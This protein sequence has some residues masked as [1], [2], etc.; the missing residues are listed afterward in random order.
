MTLINPQS[1]V[2][3]TPP[4]GQPQVLA[5]RSDHVRTQ[6]NQAVRSKPKVDR[7]TRQAPEQQREAHQ[8]DFLV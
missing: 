5:P 7:L 4:L 6:L 1:H 2:A 8:F 3:L